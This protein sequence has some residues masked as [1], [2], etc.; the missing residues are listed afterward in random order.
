MYISASK[1][2]TNNI[3]S[4]WYQHSVS[5]PRYFYYSLM[6]LKGKQIEYCSPN[7]YDWARLRV[8][9]MI[10]TVGKAYMEFNKVNSIFNSGSHAGLA[11]DKP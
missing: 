1:S 4:G 9:H 8:A 6:R 5:I 2:P 11:S 3:L 10:G 7:A